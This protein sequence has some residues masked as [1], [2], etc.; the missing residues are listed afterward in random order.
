MI[1]ISAAGILLGQ[2]IWQISNMD[3]GLG[4]ISF[5]MGV[6]STIVVLSIG[7]VQLIKRLPKHLYPL[8][9]PSPVQEINSGVLEKSGWIRISTVI[10]DRM[11][12]FN[13]PFDFPT[14]LIQDTIKM[15]QLESAIHVKNYLLDRFNGIDSEPIDKKNVARNW[16]NVYARLK[17]QNLVLYNSSNQEHILLSINIP[18]TKIKLV[19]DSDYHYDPILLKFNSA[20]IYLY[21]PTSSE[22]E[23]WFCKLCR[24]KKLPNGSE[25]DKIMEFYRDLEPVR[26]YESGMQKLQ[27][28]LKI[29]DSDSPIWLNA[30]LG[31]AFIS[32]HS[33]P[34]IKMWIMD[35]ITRRMA[36]VHRTSTS[37]LGDI[38][39]KDLDVGNSLPIISNPRLLNISSEG[40]M[41]IELDLDYTG[42]ILI[43][44]TT[45]YFG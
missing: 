20:R 32:I 15:S 4:I 10:V 34:R 5:L 11:E 23:D 39:I 18:E 45:R 9:I 12:L 6:L 38:V 14:H 26:A 1:F 40:D 41:E 17:F 25:K 29:L 31:R 3:L 7:I 42:G 8:R 27:D 22:K 36:H 37:F 24:C 2:L 44:L 43:L 21:F 19:G 35:N 13:E 30:L 16:R 33:N 28:T